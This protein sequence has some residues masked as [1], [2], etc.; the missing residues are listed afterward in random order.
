MSKIVESHH[1]LSLLSQQ[2]EGFLQLLLLR[3]LEGS[4]HGGI[5]RNMRKAKNRRA[6][7]NTSRNVDR[8]NMG[9]ERPVQH[10]TRKQNRGK[11]GEYGDG[12]VGLLNTENAKKFAHGN[13][14]CQ[15]CYTDTPS[16]S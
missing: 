1:F 13:I 6:A 3:L 14:E 2:L 10:R 11:P 16:R 5:Y 9:K 15:D 12:L 4:A 8:T 7:A